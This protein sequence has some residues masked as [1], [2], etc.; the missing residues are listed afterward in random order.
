MWR[1]MAAWDTMSD[2]PNLP[3]FIY[4]FAELWKPA[5]KLVVSHTLQPADMLAGARLLRDGIVEEV[6]R[7]KAEPGKPIAVAGATLAST[8]LDAGL[9]DEIQPFYV[10]AITGGGTPFL[11]TRHRVD[12]ELI[13]TKIFKS[14]TVYHRYGKR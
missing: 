7:L 1:T 13:E 5:A 10:P 11:Q 2:T 12:F 3:G 8:L 9:V 6:A 4:E 14:G